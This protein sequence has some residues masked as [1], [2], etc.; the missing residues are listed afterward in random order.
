VYGGDLFEPLPATLRGRVD[1]LIANAPYVPTDE[2]AFMPPEARLHE[3]PVALDGG[4]DGLDIQRR[5]VSAAPQW[6]APGGHLLVETSRRQASETVE[7]MSRAGLA[8]RVLTDDAIDAT[9]ALGTMP[10]S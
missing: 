8:A 3:A 5:V 9:A 1:L 4:R 10:A 2:I 6:L 7:V